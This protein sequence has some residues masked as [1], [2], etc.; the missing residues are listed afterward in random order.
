[1]FLSIKADIFWCTLPKTSNN[2]NQKLLG[3]LAVLIENMNHRPGESIAAVPCR[4]KPGKVNNNEQRL[5]N[6]FPYLC[7]DFEQV[8]ALKIEIYIR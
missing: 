4:W 5:M 1:M 3:T 2:I 7:V 8:S 6:N